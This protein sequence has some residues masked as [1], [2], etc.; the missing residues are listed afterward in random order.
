MP[1]LFDSDPG[2]YLL[3]VALLCWVSA[4]LSLV[5]MVEYI[6]VNRDILRQLVAR[7]PL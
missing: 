2:I 1:W 7:R 6:W 5:S 3:I 4:L